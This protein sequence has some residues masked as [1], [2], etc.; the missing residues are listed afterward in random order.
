MT[1]LSATADIWFFAVSAFLFGLVF[2]S[3][4][5]VCIYRLPKGLSVVTP[6]SACPACHTAIAAYDNVPVLSWMFLRGR[7]R[8]CKT[9][10]SPRYWIVELLTGALFALCV[11]RF[12]V[13]MEALKFCIFSF[14]LLGLI[15]T[16]ADVQILPDALTLPGIFIGLG[17]SP[18]IFVGGFIG[19]V[20]AVSAMAPLDWRIE[21]VVNASAGALLAAGFIFLVG[22]AW[23]WLR[24]VEAM[25]F[26]DVKL[27][28]MVGAFLGPKL[29][30][31]TIFLG[32][33]S[34]TAAGV[35]LA[36]RAHEKRMRRWRHEE[37]EVAHKRADRAV[38][39]IMRRFPVPF[40]VFLGTGAL[41]SAFFGD[42]LVAWYAGL[43]R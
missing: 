42:A 32:S 30:L 37:S 10:I 26:G 28:A 17:L 27:M 2:G 24:G 15:M 25:G 33:F 20:Y 14:L 36:W 29:S 13:S 3:F 7:C 34:G 31:M 43:F 35:F 4:L 6:R 12:G 1:L 39:A 38:Q 41:L 9:P 11:V 22:E 21:S 40:G 18:L 23:Y 16:D 5:N 8:H 19:L